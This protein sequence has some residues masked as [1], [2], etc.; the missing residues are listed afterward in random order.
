MDKELIQLWNPDE[1]IPVVVQGWTLQVR[2]MTNADRLQLAQRIVE[3]QQDSAGYDGLMEAAASAIISIDHHDDIISQAGGMAAFI[4][5]I[6]DVKLQRDIVNAV[7]N[8][9]LLTEE[10]EKN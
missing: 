2:T 8:Q 7:T 1:T 10:T 6:K 4:K 5:R 3:C 9:C